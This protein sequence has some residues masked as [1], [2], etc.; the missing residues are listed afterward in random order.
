MSNKINAPLHRFM[1]GQIWHFGA[2]ITSA[3]MF[4]LA[5]PACKAKRYAIT[6]VNTTNRASARGIYAKLGYITPPA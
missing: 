6:H 2:P 4:L 3:R 1:V 5:F